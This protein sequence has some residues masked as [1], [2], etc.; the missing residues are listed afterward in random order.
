VTR[1]KRRPG[2]LGWLL[3]GAVVLVAS[4]L[5]VRPGY[6]P[7]LE[8]RLFDLVNHAPDLP[9]TVV[10]VPM[11]LGNFL[12]V[13]T[14]VV[15]A[16]AVGWRRWRVA[17]ALALAGGGVYLLAKQVKHF[18]QRGRPATV[19]DGVIVRGAEAHGL[20]FVSGHVAVVTALTFVAWPW[21]PR[22]AKW[23]VGI[24]VALVCLARMYVGAHLPL[25]ISGGAGIGLAAGAAARLLLGTRAEAWRL[26]AKAVRSA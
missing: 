6:A 2:D 22:W 14:A 20:G 21:L 24:A 8:A 25:D 9:F 16:L 12:V 10:W 7:A 3:L 23:L 26:P 17:L 1:F 19:L 5:P 13:P 11:Q 18:V 4:A 15:V